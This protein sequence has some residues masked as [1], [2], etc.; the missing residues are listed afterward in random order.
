MARKYD[1]VATLGTYQKDGETKY[2]TRNVGT[3]IETQKGLRLKLEASFNPAAC[4]MDDDGRIWLA[5]FEPRD[6]QQG[7]QQPAPQTAPSGGGADFENDS[8]PF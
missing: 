1:V 6:D 3:V 8:I 2:L 7:A 5:L 4:R